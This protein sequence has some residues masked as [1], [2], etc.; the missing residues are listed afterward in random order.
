[1]NRQIIRTPL[2]NTETVYEESVL[3]VRDEQGRA[4]AKLLFDPVCVL[5]VENVITGEVYEENKD[6]KVGKDG[7]EL[8]EDSRIFAFGPRDLFPENPGPGESF[9]MPGGNS[10]FREGEFFIGRQ[11]NVTYR[12]APGQWKGIVPELA[13]KKLPRTFSLLRSGKP[14]RMVLFGDSISAAANNTRDL[15][16]PPDQPGF[17]EMLHDWL[18]DAYESDVFYVNTAVGGM[19]TNWAVEQA[20]ARVA[21]YEPDL[22]ILAF[23]M[24]DGGKTIEEFGKNTREVIRRVRAAKPD[25]EFLLVATS[26]PNPI[27]TDPRAKFWNHQEHHMKVMAAIEADTEGTAAVDIGSVHRYMM[28]RKK[29]IDMTSNNVNHPNDFFYRVHTQFLAGMLIG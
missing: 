14:F 19:E 26:L 1:M 9:P 29:F 3:M 20:E 24:N 6:Y 21:A 16:L 12:C 17:G 11:I 25:C 28:E 7:I 4:S 15:N 27:L 13:D 2:W 22:V 23:G 18:K 10:L 5:R 8:T